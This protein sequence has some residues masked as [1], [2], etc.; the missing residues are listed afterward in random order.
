MMKFIFC[1]S[2]LRNSLQSLVWK[3]CSQRF[4][5]FNT[6]IASG[7]TLAV[8]RIPA[9]KARKSLPP[10]RFRIASPITLQA[11]LSR[12]TNKTLQHSSLFCSRFTTVL[13]LWNAAR[14]FTEMFFH[15]AAFEET[16]F[17]KLLAISSRARLMP[18]RITRLLLALLPKG[19]ENCVKVARKAAIH[20]DDQHWIPPADVELMNL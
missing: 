14:A 4:R 1:A 9:L 2:C 12:Q 7:C 3:P 13:L 8:G 6:S 10:H 5:D 19:P 20:D 15:S 17:T 11:E 16:L 18:Q